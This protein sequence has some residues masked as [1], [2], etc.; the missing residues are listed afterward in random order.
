MQEHLGICD[1][2]ETIIQKCIEQNIEVIPIPGACAMINALVCSGLDTKEFL[3][4]GFLPLHKKLRKEKLEMIQK[5]NRTMIL[6]EAPH[7]L[8][9]T[10]EDLV[11]IL[12]ERQIVLAR[13]L[14]KIHEEFIRGTAKELLT[15]IEQ[16]RGEFV[17]LIEKS[18]ENE[19]ETQINELS[20]M[21][22]EEHFHYYEQQGVSKKDIIKKIAKDRQVNKNEIYQYFIER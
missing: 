10:L 7:K 9:S 21:T 20:T 5:S 15:K 14:T 6:Y 12:G 13:E 2:G 17:L 11:P 22:L 8:K 4:L 1:P 16:I 18:E 3:F 19:K